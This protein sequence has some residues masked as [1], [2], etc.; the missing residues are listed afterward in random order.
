MKV[1]GCLCLIDEGEA[2][3]KI[4]AINI[5][6]PWAAQLNDVDDVERMLPGTIDA[7]R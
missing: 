5:T 6:D 2:D 1:L 7:I 3:W 4:V